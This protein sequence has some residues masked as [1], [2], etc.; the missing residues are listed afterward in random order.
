MMISPEGYFGDYWSYVVEL[1]DGLK[2]YTKL[3]E[4]EEALSL[5]DEYNESPLQRTLLQMHLKNF[6]LVNE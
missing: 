3:W 5:W 2:A 4:D 1:S 6:K